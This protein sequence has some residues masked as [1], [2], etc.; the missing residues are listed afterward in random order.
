MS[1]NICTRAHTHTHTHTHWMQ[2]QSHMVEGNQDFTN[3][4]TR[5]MQHSGSW[6]QVFIPCLCCSKIDMNSSV[7]DDVTVWNG[8][9]VIDVSGKPTGPVFEGQAGTA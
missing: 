1:N 5:H 6:I 9:Q 2:L 4:Y 7:F 3:L 8:S